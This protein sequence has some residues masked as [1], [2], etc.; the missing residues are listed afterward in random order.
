MCHRHHRYRPRTRTA[1]LDHQQEPLYCQLGCV[2][3]FD[4]ELEVGGPYMF[5]C[6]FSL[7]LHQFVFSCI[8]VDVWYCSHL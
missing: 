5:V 1:V 2:R 8:K 3:T 7:L 4:I 6:V